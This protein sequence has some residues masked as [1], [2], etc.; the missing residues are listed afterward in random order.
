VTITA[1]PRSK[2][3]GGPAGG[4]VTATLT[5]GGAGVGPAS[6]AADATFT[7]TAPGQRNKSGTVTLEARSR[8]G[9]ARATIDLDTSQTAYTASG[10]AG[11]IT[12]R[13][14]VPDLT[15]P[16]TV[17]GTG[18]ARLTF[19]Y[20][21]TTASGRAGKM[22]YT[23]RVGGYKVSGSGSYTISGAEGGVLSLTQS[24]DACTAGPL[25]CAG[26][27]ATITLTPVG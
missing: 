18:G 4:S 7:Y 12:F 3:D 6:A 27:V 15:Q 23:G 2:M 10:T 20:A 16:F 1:A 17:K 9:V 11:N 24:I 22:T 8:R 19:S 13:G 25:A 5:A 21:P 26:G 14:T